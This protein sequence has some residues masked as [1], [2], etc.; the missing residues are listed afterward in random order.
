MAAT[1]RRKGAALKLGGLALSVKRVNLSVGPVS[2]NDCHQQLGDLTTPCAH[3]F[4]A[5]AQSLA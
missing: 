5:G 1:L 2:H 3:E 4:D